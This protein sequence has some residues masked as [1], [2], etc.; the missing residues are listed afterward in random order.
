MGW[1]P[2]LWLREY[3]LPLSNKGSGRLN[4]L[5]K[6]GE[7]LEKIKQFSDVSFPEN[8]HVF[9]WTPFSCDWPLQLTNFL[10]PSSYIQSH[11]TYLLY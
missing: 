3:V 5:P 10:K 1:S 7:A 8:T 2:F 9:H 4:I 11:T 6:S